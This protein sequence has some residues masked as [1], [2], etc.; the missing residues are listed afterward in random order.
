[1]ATRR[2]GRGGG[3]KFTK[4]K[5]KFAPKKEKEKTLLLGHLG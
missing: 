1:M 2:G 3:K 4:H 5:P